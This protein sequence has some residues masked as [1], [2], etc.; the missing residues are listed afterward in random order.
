MTT[1]DTLVIAPDRSTPLTNG[2]GTT[3]AQPLPTGPT[4]G[5]PSE[6]QP[7]VQMWYDPSCSLE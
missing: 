5:T 4:A 3:Q 2:G 6:A 1:D 7:P